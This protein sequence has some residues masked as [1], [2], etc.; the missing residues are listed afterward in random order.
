MG[1]WKG[2]SLMPKLDHATLVVSHKLNLINN[3]ISK[4]CN[5]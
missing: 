1:G 3:M 5:G 2:K 4:F